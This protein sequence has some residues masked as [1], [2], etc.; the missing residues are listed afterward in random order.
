MLKSENSRLNILIRQDSLTGLLNRKA[1]EE[2]QPITE[3][4]S[5]RRV[6]HDRCG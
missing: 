5:F 1:M 6:H 2:S 4:Q 3:R